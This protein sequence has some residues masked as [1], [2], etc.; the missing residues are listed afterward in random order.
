MQE[1]DKMYGDNNVLFKPPADAFT[2]WSLK[3][4]E[5]NL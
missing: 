5:R 4:A 1:L 3:L 2:E